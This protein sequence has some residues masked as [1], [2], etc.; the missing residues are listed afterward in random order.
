MGRMSRSGRGM[1]CQGRDDEGG[2]R[3]G[4]IFC[5]KRV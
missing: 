3:L 4:S 1:C 2:V 5:D